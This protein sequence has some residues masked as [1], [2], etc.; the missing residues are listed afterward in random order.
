MP[1]VSVS[2]Q[3]THSG[4]VMDRLTLK[5]LNC[6][7]LFLGSPTQELLTEKWAFSV[8]GS[9][10]GCVFRGLRT[11]DGSAASVRDPHRRRRPRAFRLLPLLAAAVASTCGIG[12][13][14]GS[15][16]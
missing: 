3:A 1:Q 7:K 13:G 8:R 5:G 2:S 16:L 14:C 4:E 6:P 10:L 15:S 9:N 12:G 11:N